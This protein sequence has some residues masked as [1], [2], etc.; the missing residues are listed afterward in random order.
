[1]FT[2]MRVVSLLAAVTAGSMWVGCS[3]APSRV[4]PPAI[5]AGAA[6]TAAMAQYDTNGDGAIA[7]DEL[8]G[9]A[10]INSSLDK[11]DLDG[12]KR[13]TADEITARIEAWQAS[14]VGLTSAGYEVTVNGKPSKGLKVSFE[15]E[16]FLGENVKA[17]NGTTD[18]MGMVMLDRE[19]KAD[20]PYPELPGVQLGLYVV[21]ITGGNIP[22]KY[23]TDTTLGAEIATDQEQEGMAKFELT[24]P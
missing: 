11:I 7:G 1:M 18:E 17:A 19:G 21:R 5:D 6:G 8:L 4:N 16:K 15:P 10:S 9:A 23:N 22:S 3:R 20:G 13:V 2:R 12:D 24:V 14:K